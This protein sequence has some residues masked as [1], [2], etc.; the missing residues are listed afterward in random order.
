M[1]GRRPK[2]LRTILGGGVVKL[3]VEWHYKRG[4]TKKEA[5]GIRATFDKLRREGRDS[6]WA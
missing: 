4:M 2:A 5:E 1:Q 6:V 3:E